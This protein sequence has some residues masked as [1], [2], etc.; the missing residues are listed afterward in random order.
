MPLVQEKLHVAN[1][2]TA[3]VNG[4]RP[5]EPSVEVGEF[6]VKV[7]VY[8]DVLFA[9]LDKRKFIM[10]EVARHLVFA[11]FDTKV[12]YDFWRIEF[13]QEVQ[14]NLGLPPYVYLEG[15]GHKF[16]AAEDKF[17]GILHNQIKV[18]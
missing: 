12:P 5:D 17:L 7:E 2:R 6:V 18:Q 10:G 13:S 15:Q 8:E 3:P 11:V 4:Q 16:K 9:Q 14:A 1:I